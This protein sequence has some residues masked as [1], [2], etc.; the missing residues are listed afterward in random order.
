MNTLVTLARGAY[1]PW[2]SWL[3]LFVGAFALHSKLQKGGLISTE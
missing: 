1:A 2:L 3:S